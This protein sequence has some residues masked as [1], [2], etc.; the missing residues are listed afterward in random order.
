LYLGFS[1]R[2]Q[3]FSLGVFVGRVISN[4]NNGRD[5]LKMGMFLYAEQAEEI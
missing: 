1:Y 5:F 3:R 4:M 2:D